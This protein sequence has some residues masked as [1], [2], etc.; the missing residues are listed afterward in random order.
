MAAKL[1]FA[2]LLIAGVFGPGLWAQPTGLTAAPRLARVYDAVF[3]ARFA[4]VPALL[5]QACAPPA[6]GARPDQ[7]RTGPAPAEACQ[8][9]ELVSLWWQIQL[10]PDNP[11]RDALFRAR[12]DA[13]I[14]ATEAWTAREPQRAEAW[15]YLGGAYG[16]RAQWRILRN[17]RLAAARD[18]K[19]IKDALERAI[20]LDANLED[21]YFGI[22]LYRY[23]ADVA[24][25]AAKM[26]RWL[27]LLPG[28]DR[29][30]GLREVVRARNGGA[31]LRSEAD[32]QLHVLYL[33]YEKRPEQAL[34]LLRGLR[35]RHPRNPHFPQRIAEVEDVYLHDPAASVRSLE[36]LLEAAP[37]PS[38][39]IPRH[40]RRSPPGTRRSS[41]S[42]RAPACA[43]RQAMPPPRPTGC[44]SK[45][46]VRSSAAPS[47][48]RLTRSRNRSRCGP[49]TTSRDTVGRACCSRKAAPTR[50]SPSLPRSTSDAS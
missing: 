48:P 40:W 17:E 16:A 20:A 9:M 34:D 23:Y 2:S 38:A 22:G 36:A 42:A 6:P 26:L 27:L 50:R 13:A 7:A 49:T 33:W 46:G 45:A 4:E 44:R 35:E 5:S 1:A 41:A 28:G 18:G 21:A 12:A 25:T 14:A 31:L 30:A 24:S 43:P 32:Y 37:T 29:V 11:S 3:D 47:P 39:P 10:D 19:R 15:F 8:L